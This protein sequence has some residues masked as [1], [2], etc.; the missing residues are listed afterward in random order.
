VEVLVVVGV[1][2]LLL[3]LLVPSLYSARE[4][5]RRV[6]CKNNLRQWGTAWQM[7]RNDHRDYLPT[8]GNTSPAG[9]RM[10]GT[11]YN[12]LPPYLGL[13][14]YRDFP[15]A[16]DQIE[17]L[18]NIHV[19][20]C[21]AKNLTGAYKSGSGKNQF[22][23]G[24]NQVL[25]GL[26]TE[27][28]PSSD[29]PGFLD[30]DPAHPLY[31]DSFSRSPHTVIMFDIVWNSPAGKP[32]D[33]ST[34]YQRGFRGEHMGRFHGDYANVLY[35]TGRV[36]SCKTDDLV[37]DRDFRHGDVIWDNP[38]LYWGYPPPSW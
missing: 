2:I 30:G 21:P 34:V 32:R 17:E 36:G 26:G 27:E 14:A 22:H 28:R 10:P 1:L 9:I 25:D 24:M 15:R 18:P 12:D 29:A 3:A 6:F 31:A 20:I 33:V 23:Y 11:W 19:W 5:A 4:R 35:L 13:P 37:T 7:Y 38:R 8:E 16:E